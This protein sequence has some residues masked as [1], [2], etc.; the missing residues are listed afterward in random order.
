MHVTQFQNQTIYRNTTLITKINNPFAFG[1]GSKYDKVI[2]FH[3]CHMQVLD[4]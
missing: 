3:P 1:L 2:R 4:Y